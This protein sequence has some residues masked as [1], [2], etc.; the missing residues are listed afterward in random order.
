MRKIGVMADCFRVGQV[1]GIRRAASLGADAVQL[2]IGGRG[3][4]RD[5]WT[6]SYR[7]EIRHALAEN[8][9]AFSAL[10]ADLGGHG[11]M[12]PADN[13][14]RIEETIQMMDLV[15]ELGGDTLTSHIG[16]IPP[17]PANPR[18]AVLQDA[19]SQLAIAG[20]R[21]GCRIA[22][23]TGPEAPE[24]LAGF[25]QTMP[26]NRVGINYDPANLVM[27]MGVD[28]I[29]GVETLKG[30]IYHTHA[31][32]GKMFKYVGPEVVY[33]F[34]AEGGIED[35]RMEE[36]F[37]ELPLGQ[38]DVNIPAWLAALDRIGYN[39]YL[40]IE[41]EVGVNPDGDIAEAIRFLRTL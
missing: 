31:K 38:G 3:A 22:I 32:D 16:V 1:D 12:I 13:P 34:F 7:A 24:T 2:D 30:S 29:Q 6:S 18:Y 21:I 10:C 8:G 5:R 9:L 17:D 28:P 39:G 15:R 33:G 40:T 25:L 27:V 11:F 35:L 4:I 41:R 23:E 14:A 36:C 26:N 19:M 20:E 37:I